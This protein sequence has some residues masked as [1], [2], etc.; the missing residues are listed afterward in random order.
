MEERETNLKLAEVNLDPIQKKIDSNANEAAPELPE[1]EAVET[2]TVIL[3]SVPVKNFFDTLSKLG[4][5][6][7]E[8]NSDLVQKS[9][10]HL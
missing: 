7:T 10:P 3:P 1:V 2:S 6:I 9:L 4:K 5:D 8:K